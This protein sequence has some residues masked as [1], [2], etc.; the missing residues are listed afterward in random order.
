MGVLTTGI[1]AA[2]RLIV[3]PLAGPRTLLPAAA[4]AFPP[5]RSLLGP[6]DTFSDLTAGQVPN[7]LG[8]DRLPHGPGTSYQATYASLSGSDAFNNTSTNIAIFV[9]PTNGI[10][11][12][13]PAPFMHLRYTRQLAGGINVV[14]VFEYSTGPGTWS[15][16]AGTDGTSGFR[17]TGNFVFTP[18]L[19][20]VPVSDAGTAALGTSFPIASAYYVRVTRT[21]P[22][23]GVGITEQR[24]Q[25][26][27]LASNVIDPFYAYTHAASFTNVTNVS[28]LGHCIAAANELRTKM[29]AHAADGA[30][31]DHG[32]VP[33]PDPVSFAAMPAAAT[34]K[35]TL[36]TLVAYLLTSYAAHDAG[37]KSAGGGLYHRKQYAGSNLTSV[38]APTTV[39]TCITRLND[40]KIKFNGHDNRL[41]AFQLQILSVSAAGSDGV[42]WV[43]DTGYGTDGVQSA[44]NLSV[45]G[46][47]SARLRLGDN[48]TPALVHSASVEYQMPW[49]GTP[50]TINNIASVINLLPRAPSGYTGFKDMVRITLGKAVIEYYLRGPTPANGT[51]RVRISYP[52]YPD[53]TNP[54]TAG[55]HDYIFWWQLQCTISGTTIN[56]NDFLRGY[57]NDF[58]SMGGIGVPDKSVTVAG[59]TSFPIKIERILSD[60]ASGLPELCGVVDTHIGLPNLT[61]NFV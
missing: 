52:G 26:T 21:M 10:L 16:L 2:S 19:D 57:G 27:D 29:L 35:A 1:I 15:P 32:G 51:T 9:N 24:I 42:S 4:L 50:Y 30:R 47:R 36:Q 6:T 28:N 38:V 46:T 23:G 13:D 56:L 7:F 5:S 45:P 17:L 31:H 44:A 40:L 59:P 55:G 54:D 58:N 33:T 14:P 3:D 8:E 41:D 37:A 20:W 60:P 11:V 49:D 39:A 53:Y 48:G 18:P 43:I 34:N 22:T 61:L 25:I 12:G